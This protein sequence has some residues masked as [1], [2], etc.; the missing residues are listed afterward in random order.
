MEISSNNNSTYSSFNYTGI[1]ILV[2]TNDLIVSHV[3][4][5]F[6]VTFGLTL[7]NVVGIGLLELGLIFIEEDSNR[8]TDPTQL[9]DFHN[10]SAEGSAARLVGVKGTSGEKFTWHKISVSVQWIPEQKTG[11]YVLCFSD[12]TEL[13][14]SQEVQGQISQ[15][16]N[17]WETTVDALQDVVT[18]QNKKMEIVRANKMAHDLFG[19]ELGELTGKKCYEAF[20]RRQEPCAGCPVYKTGKDRCPHTG[21]IY[22]PLVNRTF[23]VSSFPIVDE[24]GE[25][26]QLVHVARDVS[27]YLRNESEKNRLMAAIEQ[28]SESVIITD[29]KADIQYVNPA[30]EQV[31]G[32][33]RE[34]V[35]GKSLDIIKS[36]AHEE[37]FYKAMWETL[38]NKQVWRGRLTHRRKNGTLYKE[39]AA[40]S[41]VQNN[42]GEITNFVA[43]KRDVTREDQL[44]RQ[45]QQAMKM[46]ALGT[47][48]GGI[49]HD[50]NNIL[51]AMIGYVEIARG[52][53]DHDHP[54]Q[55]D[56]Q[57]VLASGDR[58]VD[59]V[60]Q[61]LTFSRKE[62]HP[63][64]QQVKVQYIISEIVKLL[65]PSLPA[66]IE[67]IH[68]IDNSCRPVY[69]DQGQIY[70]VIMNLCT[71]A[72]QAIGTEHGTITIKL[73]E[74][75][76]NENLTPHSQPGNTNAY[77]ELSISD[78]GCGIQ[79]DMLA[80]IYDPFFTTKAKD[81]GTGLGLAVVHGVI[82]KH[83]GEIH[84]SSVPG[85]GTSFQIY[86]A[87]ADSLAEG[88]HNEDS[89]E[90]GG[91]ERIMV[92]DDEPSVADVIALGL[93]KAGYTVLVYN[94]SLKAVEMFRENPDCCDLVITD[95][96]M[97]NMTGAEVSRELL[98]IRKNLPIIMLTGHS[99]HFNKTKALRLGI[100]EFVFKPVKRQKLLQHIREVL[101]DA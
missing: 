49:A 29:I 85:E 44:E 75:G 36:G 50:F 4:R 87:V 16:K 64:F 94:D 80:N 56:L 12:V 54:V 97:P 71:N 60:K 17:E 33:G 3:N 82:K 43:I 101:A 6:E 88:S 90:I 23:S 22:N 68:D 92:L 30:F 53:I 5:S 47:L 74:M 79:D 66:T 48:A 26:N 67:L 19:F 11:C 70:Q 61:I 10:V 24:S 59:L 98:S 39:D 46:E 63:Q 40:I 69:A 81:H 45:L 31:T 83:K 1:P 86:L 37:Q 96:L 28:A 73:R 84:V 93:K 57:Q 42:R 41:P 27:Q 35:I 8:I 62:N 15:A 14:G 13:V 100:K 38:F 34:E 51:S 55:N 7:K 58:A 20:F 76:V 52:K 32:Y 2:L 9:F 95:M 91:S 78:T 18:I 65:R 77:M 99:E 21:S 72:R 89:V 25:M